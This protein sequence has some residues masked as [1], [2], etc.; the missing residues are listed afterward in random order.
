MKQ[1]IHKIEGSVISRRLYNDLSPHEQR[2][3]REIE[4]SEDDGVVDDIIG[5]GAGLLIDELTDNIGP[6]D[7]G[8]DN[9]EGFDGFGGGSGGGGGADNEW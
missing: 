6:F 5:I 3:Y 1:Y 2:N 9:D 7:T 8:S 4:G